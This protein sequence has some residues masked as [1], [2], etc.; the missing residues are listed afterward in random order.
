MGHDLR[1]LWLG[2]RYIW[3]CDGLTGAN[4]DLADTKFEHIMV[5]RR[6]ISSCCAWGLSAHTPPSVLG[7]LMNSSP[8][9]LDT[10]FALD[11]RGRSGL[12]GGRLL[13]QRSSWIK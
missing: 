11:V 9:V 10:W 12:G 2:G 8:L 7:T 6:E 13:W 1:L 3:A 5:V 4:L